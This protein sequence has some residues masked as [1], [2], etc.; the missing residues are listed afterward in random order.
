MNAVR[1]PGKEDGVRRTCEKSKLKWFSL[2]SDG[3]PAQT[4]G[5]SRVELGTVGGITR[6]KL[7]VM[8]G[9]E[10]IWTNCLKAFC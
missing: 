5:L 2:G 1:K 7:V 9:L 6:A 3:R 8:P 4:E 10:K